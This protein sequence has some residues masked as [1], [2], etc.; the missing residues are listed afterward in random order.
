MTL[1]KAIMRCFGYKGTFEQFVKRY[2]NLKVLEIN[3]AGRLDR[4]L[5][6]MPNHTLASYPEVDMMQLPYANGYFD[7]VVHSDTLE[8][9]EA[10]ITGL[11]EI[12]RVLKPNGFTCYT[13]PII[14]DRLTSTRK[15]K[16]PS[17]H[18][19]PG[20]DEH[21]VQTEYG[22]DMW[23]QLFHAGF[24]ECRLLS[25]DYPASVAITAMKDGSSFTE[26][27]LK[28]SLQKISIRLKN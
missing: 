14:I 23:T 3:E 27:S 15:N 6:Q 24:T 12:F 4:Y 1:A 10:P 5:A 22:S 7:L 21:L 16:S 11:S 13:I 19:T 26:K 18:G 9:V 28:A 17:Y 25:I 8:H 20:N 2:K